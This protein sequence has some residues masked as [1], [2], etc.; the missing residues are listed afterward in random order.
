MHVKDKLGMLAAWGILL[1][2]VELIAHASPDSSD[3][4]ERN[5]AIRKDYNALTDSIER[6]LSSESDCT[7]SLQGEIFA[8]PIDIRDPADSSRI[9]AAVGDYHP[10]GWTI[11]RLEL[12]NI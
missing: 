10:I 6:L 4:A 5:S 9:I 8:D 12:K 7:A 1:L 11:T 2:T 3:K